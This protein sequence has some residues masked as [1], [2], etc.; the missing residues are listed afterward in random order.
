MPS[1]PY[2]APVALVL[3]ASLLTGCGKDVDPAG[4]AAAVRDFYGHLGRGEFGPACDLLAPDLRDSLVEAGGGAPCGELLRQ[5]SD[6]EDRA[7]MVS[8]DVDVTKVDTSGA[9]VAVP[10]DAITFGG[11]PSTGGDLRLLRQGDRWLISDI[12]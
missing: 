7:A 11:E 12:K 10:E 4:P 8:T 5:L 9:A 6:G 3:A 2:A 1:L